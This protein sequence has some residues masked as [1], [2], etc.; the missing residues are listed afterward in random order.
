MIYRV[1]FNSAENKIDTIEC[2][3]FKYVTPKKIYGSILNEVTIV[4]NAYCDGDEPT[5]VLLTG[6]AGAGKTLFANLLVNFGIRT[7]QD[8]YI[9]DAMKYTDE[10]INFLSDLKNCIVFI[11]EFEKVIDRD[12]QQKLLPLLTEDNH[13]L[14]IFAAN[15]AYQ[16]IPQILNRP[17]RL[18]YHYVF[19]R[20]EDNIIE[21]YC[22]D[23]NAPISFQNQ[24]L[25]INLNSDLFSFNALETLVSESI[26]RGIWDVN[27]HFKRL[28]LQG[29][30]R[31]KLFK[32]VSIV[33]IENNDMIIPVPSKCYTNIDKIIFD[34]PDEII[35]H[36]VIEC[37]NNNENKDNIISMLKE[38]QQQFLVTSFKRNYNIGDN[39]NCEEFIINLAK[40]IK[41]TVNKQR[42]EDRIQNTFNDFAIPIL[43][44][45]GI[46]FSEKINIILKGVD[47]YMVPDKS[48]ELNIV[49]KDSTEK[50]YITIEKISSKY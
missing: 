40:C 37:I 42:P 38:P 47:R 14:F 13:V 20:M 46:N 32:V 7:K 26:K 24:L 17:Q 16:I 28:N 6:R 12:T 35:I 11:D 2:P 41:E 36:K 39:T 21:E 9:F 4:W 44:N 30:K 34:V 25:D 18:R 8:V 19:E 43:N 3:G 50:W 31:M 29:L 5:S 48:N 15:Y 33:N 23:F 22:K 1:R 27:E 49:Y 45:N 10:V